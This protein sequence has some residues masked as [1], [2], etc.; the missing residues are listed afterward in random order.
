MNLVLHTV[1]PENGVQRPESPNSHQ[2]GDNDDNPC[3][4]GAP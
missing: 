4:F 2:N 1:V 3:E